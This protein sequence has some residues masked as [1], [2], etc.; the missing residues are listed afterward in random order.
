MLQDK[1]RMCISVL[2]NKAPDWHWRL[3]PRNLDMKCEE[4]CVLGLLYGNY[5]DGKV[6]LGIDDKQAYKLGLLS[7][8]QQSYDWSQW[9]PFV[10][11][12]LTRAWQKAIIDKRKS[13]EFEHLMTG[14]PTYLEVEELYR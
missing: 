10:G 13:D 2:D 11:T 6:K 12:R 4:Y 3:D 8:F 9:L 14:L 5:E 7:W 1:I